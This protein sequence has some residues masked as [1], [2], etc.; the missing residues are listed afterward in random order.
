MS[1]VH[2]EEERGA[3]VAVPKAALTLAAT[4]AL[5][6]IAL[7]AAARHASR[8]AGAPGVRPVATRAL[9]FSDR[10]DGAVG[11]YDAVRRESLPPLVGSGGFVRG[12]LRAL[13]RQRRLDAVGPDVPF[14][15]ARWPDGRLT[16][17]DS[18]T[19]EHLELRAYGP[20]NE[21]AFA[22]LLPVGPR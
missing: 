3:E 5:L 19:H 21:A 16:L 12:A 17:D 20:T 22:A 18:A 13:A 10:P 14:Y 9:V 1:Y 6:T 4:L 2:I 11:V 7:A 15:L 8:P